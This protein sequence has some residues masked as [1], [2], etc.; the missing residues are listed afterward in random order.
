MTTTTAITAPRSAATPR[1]RRRGL[2]RRRTVIAWAFMLPLVATN[3][4]VVLGPSVF[5]LYYSFTDWGGIG[6]A[7]WIGLDNYVE[8][9]GDPEFRNALWH[10]I[11]WT[12]FFLVVP[13]TMGLF[14]AFALTRIRR[15]RLLF[16]VAFFVPYIV[17]SVVTAAI[18][19]NLLSP[20]V[21]IGE[22]LGV[23]F[24]GST[25]LALPT[26]AFVNNWA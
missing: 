4:L 15:F 6:E 2:A 25:S 20:D 19:E 11:V 18:W 26:V 5:A 12:A 22:A 10:N 13:M 23:N 24:L 9:A 17:A 1:T 14:G 21:G 16:R 3:L 8:L 7:R